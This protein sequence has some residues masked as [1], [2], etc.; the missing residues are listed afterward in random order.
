VVSE[1]AAVQP[2]AAARVAEDAPAAAQVQM[3]WELHDREVWGLV[4]VQ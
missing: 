4:S 2:G 3:N 1:A